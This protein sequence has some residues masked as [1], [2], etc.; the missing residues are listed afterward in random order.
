MLEPGTRVSH[1][2]V[3]LASRVGCL[4]VWIGE[5][6]VRLYPSGQP[7]GA[8]ADRLLYQANMA[9]KIQPVRFQGILQVV[10]PGALQETTIKGIGP[11][12]SFG[13]GLLSL[14]RI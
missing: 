11:A 14:A 3:V 8:R 6:G 7:E 1:A 9:G 10:N 4:L 13:C 12:K 2:A 5:A